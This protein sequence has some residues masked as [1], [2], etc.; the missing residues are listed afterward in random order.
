MRTTAELA[1]MG[2]AAGTKLRNTE[3]WSAQPA[4]VI[5]EKPISAHPATVATFARLGWTDGGET[6][7]ICGY[8]RQCNGIMQ[9]SPS[10]SQHG[11]VLPGYPGVVSFVSFG[12]GLT[13]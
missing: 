5:R 11:R 12:R 6:D 1:L 3:T 10:L 8:P 4:S 2:T 9:C 7:C 13:I